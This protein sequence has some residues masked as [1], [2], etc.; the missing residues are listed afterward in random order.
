[1]DDAQEGMLREEIALAN[2]ATAAYNSFIKGFLEQRKKDLYTVFTELGN[3]DTEGLMEVK[4]MLYTLEVLEN[5]ISNIMIT[6]SLAR[7]TIEEKENAT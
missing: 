3:T 7:A 6:G 5:D 2:K 1:M 4:R